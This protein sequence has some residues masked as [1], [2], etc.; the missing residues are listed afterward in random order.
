MAKAIDDVGLS[1]TDMI[2]ITVGSGCSGQA[3]FH[4]VPSAIP[5]TIQAEDF[6][7]G[8]EGVAY[9]DADAGNNGGQYRTLEDVDI[10]N[11]SDAG[12]GY[13]VGWMANNEWL[14]YAVDVAIP[15]EYQIDVRVA[16]YTTGGNFHVEFDGEDKTGN[17]HVPVTGWWQNW[18]TV[19]SVATLSAGVQTMRFVNADAADEYN[20]NYFNYALL[21]PL[22]DFDRD[23]DVDL[24]DFASMPDCLTGPENEPATGDCDSFDYDTDADVDLADFAEFQQALTR[25]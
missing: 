7:I 2:E 18:V 23:G 12:G 21:Y 16:S 15:G 19:S 3:P 13:N 10:E 9:Q 1:S 14:E 11:C 24:A 5:G 22:G 4:G 17:I 25:R 6:D 8:G 20:L